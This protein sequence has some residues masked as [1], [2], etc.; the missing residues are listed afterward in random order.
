MRYVVFGDTAIGV[1]NATCCQPVDDS[2]ANVALPSSVPVFV[3]S[4]A[5]CVPVFSVLL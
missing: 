5:T 1:A 4:L 3:H 2:P